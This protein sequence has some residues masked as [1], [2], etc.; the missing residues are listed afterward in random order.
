MNGYRKDLQNVTAGLG[1]TFLPPENF[2]APDHVDW[3]DHGYV[4]PVKSQGQCGSCW[5]FAAVRTIIILEV[6]KWEE[7]SYTV[8]LITGRSLRRTNEKENW[9]ACVS[10]CSGLGGLLT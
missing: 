9:K 6:E 3:R 1:G 5:S 10:F 8:L 7:T 2:K 4:T